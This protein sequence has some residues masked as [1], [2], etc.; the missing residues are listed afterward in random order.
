[1]EKK[2]VGT[3]ASKGLVKEPA[4]ERADFWVGRLVR[5]FMVRC[6]NT[7][8]QPTKTGKK[9]NYKYLTL[10]FRGYKH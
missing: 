3:G 8:Q 7:V 5:A 2:S 9:E 4:L 6:S 10:L 1:M